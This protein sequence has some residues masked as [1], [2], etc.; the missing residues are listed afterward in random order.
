MRL[1][2]VG[3]RLFGLSDE[4][5][6]LVQHA[7]A[8]TL[9]RKRMAALRL[10]GA[11]SAGQRVDGPHRGLGRGRLWPA[12][13]GRQ[14]WAPSV[15]A[16]GTGVSG[17]WCLRTAPSGWLSPGLPFLGHCRA[18]HRAVCTL[19]ADFFLDPHIQSRKRDALFPAPDT[20]VPGGSSS[21]PCGR[22]RQ[23]T[24]WGPRRPA[25]WLPVSPFPPVKWGQ[26]AHTPWG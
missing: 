24:R 11:V 1:T 8:W 17:A 3:T 7:R 15:L 6:W 2:G 16:W 25:S 21:H 5:A 13:P 22:E 9:G 14:A 19:L 12:T 26:P 18:K 10:C 4:Q 20:P 23:Q